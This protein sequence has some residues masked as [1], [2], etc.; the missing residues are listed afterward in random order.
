[1]MYYTSVPDQNKRRTIG[2]F[3]YFFFVFFT[4][5]VYPWVYVYCLLP[6]QAE[7]PAQY[8]RWCL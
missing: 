7:L 3:S 4:I 5:D 2:V 1:M 6:G 8:G